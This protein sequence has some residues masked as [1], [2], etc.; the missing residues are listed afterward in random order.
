MTLNCTCHI[1]EQTMLKAL[2]MTGK[3]SWSVTFYPM[4]NNFKQYFYVKRCHTENYICMNVQNNAI[5]R[6]F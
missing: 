4:L 3:P 2:Q 5:Q 1:W 6:H